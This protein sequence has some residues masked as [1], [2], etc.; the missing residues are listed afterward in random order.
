MKHIAL[1]EDYSLVLHE[2]GERGEEDLTELAES[3]NLDRP[4]L[5]HIIQTLKCKGLVSM[6]DN[7]RG[8]WIRL[9][10]K[11]RKF[12]SALWPEAHPGL[13]YGY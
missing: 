10:A 1:P 13:A 2:V 12:M 8:I 4:R 5:M 9:S 11:G 7:G 3:L 6:S